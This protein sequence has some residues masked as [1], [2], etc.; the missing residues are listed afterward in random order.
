MKLF[1]AALAGALVASPAL[2]HQIAG[3]LLVN[4]TASP[5][6]KYVRNVFSEF[7]NPPGA[8]P[9]GS[10][11][12]KTP[13]LMDITNPNITCGRAAF[14]S[15]PTT[16][17]A[18]VLAGSEI[19]FRVSWDGNGPGGV[20]WH[21]GPGQVYISQVPGEV[22]GGL[23]GFHGREGEWFKIAYAGPVS[24]REWTLWGAHDFNFTIP[25]T[26]PP[27]AYLMRLE[28]WLPTKMYNYSQWY[29]NCA[30]INVIGPGGG[31]PTGFAKFPG[32][33]TVDSPGLQ[34]PENQVVDG[35]WVPDDQLRLLEYQA[36]GPDVWTG[37]A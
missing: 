7:Y 30:H 21:P 17:T 27:G 13:P 5:E 32:T 1:Q 24:N 11:F 16:E 29:V 31:T 23:G 3:I 8:Y 6:W 19:G 28:Q 35:G 10:Q 12:P 18:D 4:N 22:E 34:I 33:Y 15:A 36:P 14:D 26:T 9:D 37:E 25:A 2:A 20:F